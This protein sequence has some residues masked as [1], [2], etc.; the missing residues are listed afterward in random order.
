MNNKY[1]DLSN[2]ILEILIENHGVK[3]TNLL[4][5]D[6]TFNLNRFFELNEDKIIKLIKE[7]QA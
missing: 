6:D 5:L 1:T 2:S 4:R 7:V 3:L